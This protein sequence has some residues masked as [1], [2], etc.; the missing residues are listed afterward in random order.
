[1]ALRQAFVVRFEAL[2]ACEVRTRSGIAKRTVRSESDYSLMER[3]IT[4]RAV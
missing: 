2:A 3:G 1:M 4:A